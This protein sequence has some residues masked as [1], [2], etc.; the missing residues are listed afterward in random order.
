LEQVSLSDIELYYSPEKIENSFI[1]ILGDECHHI[2][3]VMR[4]KINDE[5]FV[6]NGKGSIY[7]TI[8]EQIDKKIITSRIVEE[9]KYSNKLENIT[10]CIP[11]LK[12]S[13]RFDFA[14]EKCVE[15]GITKFIVFESG[16]TIA[17]GDK[18][19]KWEKHL[20]A[21][22]KQSLRAWLP[23]ISY[24]KN[25]NELI[26]LNGKKIIFEQNSEISFNDFLIS[27]YSPLNTKYYFIFGPEG[28]LTN[29][30]CRVELASVNG[31][32]VECRVK[33]TDNRLRSETAIVAA[34]SMLSLNL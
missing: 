14:L 16:R 5:V 13:D 1:K 24:I 21:A 12:S 34:A 27:Q 8:I 7:R 10:F 23:E 6:A 17:K 32:N 15:L 29:D 31:G 18:T 28:G 2:K 19:G 26:R 3:D 22:M 9:L 11:R 20:I 30:E 4:H 25:Y 33:L